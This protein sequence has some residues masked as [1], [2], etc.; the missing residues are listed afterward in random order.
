[1]MRT[2]TMFTRERVRAGAGP[3]S[4]QPRKVRAAR[5]HDHGDEDRGHPVH[6]ALD[7][8]LAGLGLL[9]Q[10]DDLG[11]DHVLAHPGGPE[12]QEA[13]LVQRRAPDLGILLLGHGKALAGEHGLVDAARPFNDHAV[14]RDFLPRAHH[15]QIPHGHLGQGHLHFLAVPA[16]AGGGGGQG[17]EAADGLRGPA[18]GAGLQP[19]PQEDEGDDHDGGVEVHRGGLP[20]G[21]HGPREKRHPGGVAVGRGGAQGH[22]GVHAGGEV[23]GG[24]ECADEKGGAGIEEDRGGEDEQHNMPDMLGKAQ[25]AGQGGHQV[26]Q[27]DREA[28]GQGDEKAPFEDAGFNLGG[29]GRRGLLG[30]GLHFVARLGDGLLQGVDVGGARVKPHFGAAGGEIDLGPRHPGGLGEGSFH[31]GHAGGA[32]QAAQGEGHFFFGSRH[33]NFFRMMRTRMV[34]FLPNSIISLLRK[35][36]N[37]SLWGRGVPRAGSPCYRGRRPLPHPPLKHSFFFWS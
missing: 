2:A 15:D 20:G 26:P 13:P 31:P 21:G 14:H 30:P 1:M 22:Q 29:R 3:N 24:L 36:Y 6:Q 33:R 16:E 25:P 9:H 28:Q 27:D 11:E 10:P 32:V 23:H 37:C 4:S 18:P 12:D 35:R 7:G 19:A 5:I 17:K 8:G 34:F